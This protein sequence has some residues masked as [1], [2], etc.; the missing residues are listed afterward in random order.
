MNPTEN[1]A[2]DR[3]QQLSD[4][5]LQYVDAVESGQAPDRR[6]VLAR[7]PEFADD[8]REFFA[9]RDQL[10]LLA[11]PLRAAAGLSAARRAP[12][13]EAPKSEARGTP[14]ELGQI[15]DFRLLRE[16]GR[17]GM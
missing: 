5:L 7:H 9:G 6:E 17:G 2:P 15:G 10:E 13:T 4:I 8:L 16:V 11:A 3:E 14:E 12:S 1:A